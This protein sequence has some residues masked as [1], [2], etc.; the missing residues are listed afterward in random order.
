MRNVSTSFQRR[1]AT[2]D[3]TAPRSGLSLLEVV[4][5]LTILAIASAYISQG[6]RIATQNALK[7]QRITQAEMVAESVMNQVIAGVI[8]A[9]PVTWTDYLSPSGMSLAAQ[10]GWMYQILSVPSEVTGMVGIQV[11]VQYADPNSGGFNESSYDL[12]V[13]RW[14]IDPTLGLD[15]PPEEELEEEMSSS[16]SSSSSSAASSSN[17][18]SAGSSATSGTSS[19]AGAATAGGRGGN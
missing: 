7:A 17:A 1:S 15:T 4:L 13:N 6:M 14:M 3:S 16:S 12:S 18:A 11:A 9:Q 2:S 8:P 5:A 10:Q 19:A